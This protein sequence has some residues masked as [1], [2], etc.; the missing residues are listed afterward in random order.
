MRFSRRGSGGSTVGRVRRR[1]ASALVVLVVA[2]AGL[3]WPPSAVGAPVGATGKEPRSSA[4]PDPP[5]AI[6]GDER[7]PVPAFPDENWIVDPPEVGVDIPEDVPP[8]QFADALDLLPD[9]GGPNLDVFAAPNNPGAGH[10]ALLYGDDV[11]EQK[12]NGSWGRIDTSFRAS[13]ANSWSAQVPGLTLQ[14][15]SE[16]APGAPVR[17]EIHGVGTMTVEPEGLSGAIHGEVAGSLIAYRDAL[18]DTDLVYSAT[19]HGYSEQVVLKAPSAP[20]I[21]SY[22]ISAPGL[23]LRLEPTGEV[24]LLRGA[25]V[26]GAIPPALTWDSSD[27]PQTTVS[28]YR[29]EDLGSQG[30]RLVIEVDPAFL[31]GAQYPV[32]VDPSPA[33]SISSDSSDTYVDS[34]SPGTSFAGSPELWVSAGTRTR[35]T[36]VRFDTAPLQRDDRIV[37][38]GELTLYRTS[39]AGGA[40]TLVHR[41]TQAWPSGL[42]WNNQPTVGEQ[43]GMNDWPCCAGG[44]MFWDVKPYL[45][46]ILQTGYAD[47]WVDY[48]LR[49]ST[50]GTSAYSFRSRDTG[51]S[52]AHLNV[53]LYQIVYNDLPDAPTPDTPAVGFVSEND[54]PTLKIQGGASWPSDPNGDEVLVQFQISDSATDW[55]VQHVKW[56]SGWTD[57][58]SVVVP[59]GVLVDGTTYYWRARSWDICASSSQQEPSSLGMCKLTDG[60]GIKHEQHASAPR[61]LTIS[62]KHFG[63]DPRYAMWSHDA[64]NGVTIKVNEANGNLFLD[65]PP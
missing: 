8:D 41:V 7:L 39:G 43:V 22:L 32:T 48:G 62:L 51:T 23:A 35:H 1:A 18:V 64:G 12:P 11:N 55:T 53:Q 38:Q 59:T 49:V 15:P 14:F 28:A 4:A 30:Y 37:Y 19:L 47:H 31:A 27:Q 58:R 21:L 13:G 3:P 57:E 26:V 61:A 33:V 42:T 44:W 52:A 20:S 9:K 24:S 29:L 63:D 25:E 36:F 65:V 6:P 16:L 56:E 2:F 40:N 10:V 45:Q 5:A 46:H 54:S 60:A 17:F 34:L 50:S